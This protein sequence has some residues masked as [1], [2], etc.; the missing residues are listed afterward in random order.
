MKYP[1]FLPVCL[2]AGL[3]APALAL[4]GMDITTAKSTLTT[5]QNTPLSNE[6]KQRRKTDLASFDKIGIGNY[7]AQYYLDGG[8]QLM[9][10]MYATLEP[11]LVD[12]VVLFVTPATA[13]DLS[14]ARGLKLVEL[15]YAESSKASQIVPDLKAARDQEYKNQYNQKSLTYE[16]KSLLPRAYDGYLYYLGTL[17]GYRIGLQKGGLQVCI[18]HRSALKSQ[19][20]DIKRRLYP[21]PPPPPPPPPP[22]PPL[23]TPR[24]KLV[25]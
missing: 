10:W 25:W 19:I 9:I 14:F 1:F 5:R 13:K 7:F 12:E 11:Q 2:L 17:F 20:D 6:F 18:Y 3:A 23:P 8:H 16:D 22:L 21:D 4:P 15:I 24:P